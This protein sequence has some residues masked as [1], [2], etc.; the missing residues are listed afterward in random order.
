MITSADPDHLDIYH[1]PEAYRESFEHFTSLISSEGALVMK[2][3]IPVTPR[4]KEGTR[5]FTYTAG[6]D[7]ADFRA[8][9]IEIR[10]G[11]L[12]FDWHYPAIEGRPQVRSTSNSVYPSSSMWRMPWQLWP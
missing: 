11:H 10:D 5:L 9:G 1:T 4:L 3:G 6:A 12:F 7:E 2:K 8:D